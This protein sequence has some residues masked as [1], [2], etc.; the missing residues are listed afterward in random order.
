MLTF[1]FRC[2]LSGDPVH[3]RCLIKPCA[4]TL[5]ISVVVFPTDCLCSQ[6]EVDSRMMD[7]NFNA[8]F[9]SVLHVCVYIAIPPVS[10]LIC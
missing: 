10:M 5:L 7:L 1:S 4:L 8:L 3:V 6:D 9:F 2:P